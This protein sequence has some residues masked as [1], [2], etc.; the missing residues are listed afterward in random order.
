L[1][2]MQ[3]LMWDV[4]G[5]YSDSLL[6]RDH[7]YLF[8]PPDRTGRGGLAR[9]G[10]SPPPSACEVTAE[11]LR[12]APP[13]MV[14]LQWLEEI[15]L[16]RTL[17]GRTP[18]ADLTAIFLEQARRRLTSPTHGIRLADANGIA[19]VHVTYF[20][21]LIWECGATPTVIEHGLADPGFRYTADPR[22]ACV[23]GQRAGTPLANHRRRPVAGASPR[24]RSS[25]SIVRPGVTP[26]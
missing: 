16:W 20:N 10:G 13:D 19:I 12:D 3:I 17:L 22:A 26:A 8:L 24:S 2:I 25:R 6:A 21:D 7:D 1:I 5:G 14:V 18:G 11:A 15:E 9:F 23:R 4:H